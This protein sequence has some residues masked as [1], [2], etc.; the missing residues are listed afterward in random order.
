MAAS[1]YSYSMSTRTQMVVFLATYHFS[2]QY[3]TVFC[4]EYQ[5]GGD[6]GWVVPPPNDTKIYNDWASE[7][8]FELGDTVRMLDHSEAFYFISGVSG[9]HEKGQRMIIT[10]MLEDQDSSSSSSSSSS[11][12]GGGSN[13][14]LVKQRK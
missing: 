9:H 4:F 3:L 12:S 10:V 11:P 7:N 14:V 8:R 2:L 6:I 5:L 1:H 13:S